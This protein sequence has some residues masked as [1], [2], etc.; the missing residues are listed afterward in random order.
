MV[1]RVRQPRRLRRGHLPAAPIPFEQMYTGSHK[2]FEVPDSS[3]QAARILERAEL[4]STALLKTALAITTPPR[5]VNPTRADSHSRTRSSSPPT[6]IH[7]NTVPDRSSTAFAPDATKR[8]RLLH[9]RDLAGRHRI[10]MDST[11]RAGFATARIGEAQF[12]WI[13]QTLL[14]GS[15]KYTTHTVPR[16]AEPH[17]KPTS[18]CFSHHTSRRWETPAGSP[19][20]PLE[21]RIKGAR[22]WTFCTLP[23]VLAWVNGHTHET[24]ITPQVGRTPEQGFWEINTASHIDFPPAGTHHRWRRQP[25]RDRLA[26]HHAD[27]GETAPTRSITT[28]SPRG[29]GRC[30]GSSRSTTS[31]RIEAAGR[32]PDHNVELVLATLR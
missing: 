5:T 16:Q 27:R 2:K 11:N 17:T 24:R 18:C 7:A 4:R 14:A 15:S 22:W 20:V 21:P 26:A 32:L 30:I 28:T 13:E 8:D 31:K 29:L 3:D 23:D 12:K 9:V 19:N 1:L 25:R 6:S 10:S